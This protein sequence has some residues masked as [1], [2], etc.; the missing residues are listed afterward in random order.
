MARST[1]LTKGNITR[2]LWGFALPLMLGNVLQ[3]LYNLVDTWVVGRYVGDNALAAVGSSYTLMTFLTSV[4]IGLCLGSSSFVSM[5]YGRKDVK[6]IRNGIFLSSS[7][8]GAIAVVIMALFYILVDKII[9]LLQ[10]PYEIAGD[11]KEYLIYVFIGFIAIYIYNYVSNILRGIG[12]SV[13]PLVFLSVSVVLNIF[14]D[15]LFV[16]GFNMGIKGAA[17]ATVIAQYISGIGIFIYMIAAYPEYRIHKDDMQFNKENITNIF[18]LSGFT[19]LQQSVMN[20]GIL[21]VQGIVNSFG[22][23]IMA[24]FAVAVKIDTIAYMPVQ[25]FG[26]AFSVFA[27]QNFGAGKYDRMKKSVRIGL[28]MGLC[29][30]LTLTLIFYNFGTPLFRL[31]TSDENV[32]SIGMQ[33]LYHV[34][35][36]YCLFV[37]IELLSGAL[38]G[39]GDVVIPMLI[40]CFGVCLLRIAWLFFIV[41]LAPGLN[42]I[43][44]SYPVTW[45]ITAVMFIVY[46]CYQ[47]KKWPKS[48]AKKTA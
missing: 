27:A 31:F 30:A 19:C 45:A 10:V 7:M 48:S 46:Y 8:I 33:M 9:L 5:A 6:A 2:G 21:C 25:D 44:L 22:T 42:T 23:V 20:F 3:Q 37:F 29:T 18:S 4:I 36:A 1:D 26:N 12:N 11:M 40:T 16:A 41:P 38:R 17:A 35:P 15:I 24:A 32:V 34:A 14:L 39:T 43:V 13:V 47:A 28:C